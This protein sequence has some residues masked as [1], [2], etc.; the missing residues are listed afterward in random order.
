MSGILL[1]LA[2]L[3]FL[4]A[5]F[6]GAETAFTAL[7][8]SRAEVLRGERSALSRRLVF[9]YD[10]LDIVI[11]VNLIVSNLVNIVISAYITVLATGY[12]GP[13][14]IAY[15]VA[16]GT[17]LIL[18]FGE[19]IPK[20]LA[21]LFP[22][23]FSKFAT[24]ILY[25]LYYLLYP[26]VVPLS[27]MTRSIDRCAQGDGNRPNEVS[28][29]EVEAMLHLGKKDGALES[30]EYEMIKNLLLLND[31]EARHIMTRRADIV[32]IDQD[33]TLLELLELSAKHNLSRFP[34]FKEDISDIDW[35]ISI[36]KLIPYFTDAKNLNKKIKEFAPHT[37]FKIPETKYLDDLFFEFQKKRVHLAIVL[38]EFGET[39]GLITLEDVVEEIF[40]DIEDETDIV[41]VKIRKNQKGDIFCDGDVGLSELLQFMKIVP[42]RKQKL[43]LDKSISWLILERLHRFPKEG[44]QI[45]LK[46]FGITAHV[47]DMDDECIDVIRVEKVKKE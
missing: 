32:G 42:P 16:T 4:S 9:L 2:V 7:S 3:L 39:S 25:L 15:A 38:D 41:E 17:V 19:I 45:E 13:E 33:A 20:K 28:E 29:E 46:E 23:H 14:G 37:A 12:F 24:P 27:R 43:H 44:E 8:S 11:M 47:V 22:V 21:I 6:S 26:I 36:P 35:I 10:R 40:G 5:L 34:V 30:K 31:K 18:V 1:T